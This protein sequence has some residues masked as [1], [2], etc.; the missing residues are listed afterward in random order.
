MDTEEFSGRDG[1]RC[2]FVALVGRPNVG[3]STLLNAL[4]G[5]KISIVTP[6]PQTT[7]HRINGILTLDGTQLVFVDTPGLHQRGRKALNAALNRTA[8]AS[9]S[10]VDVV[11]F[12][13]EAGRW[14]DEDEAVLRHLQGVRAPVGL[15]LNKVDR[16]ADR[17]R[18]L[19]ELQK[20][21]ERR[22]FAFV[23]PLS[24]RRRDNLDALIGEVQRRLPESPFLYPDDQ[25]TDRSERFLV[26]EVVREK[27]VLALHDELPYELTVEVER[28]ERDG[29]LLT[30]GAV[31]WVAKT[32]HKGIVI[33][34]G[35][36][37]LKH[38]GE[39]ARLEL[40]ERFGEKV[41]LQLWVKVKEGWHE[42]ERL[43]RSLGVDES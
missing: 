8:L 32:S 4:V 13:V 38:V 14:T 28:F 19:P 31:I 3:K 26:A 5:E 15:V 9:L 20:L 29:R 30:L 33:G 2:G 39:K 12:V 25:P 11:L 27:L 23:V 35:G 16:V 24:A 7:R 36:H 42:S 22:E 40:E 37:T 18:L 1:A 41:H 17:S 34:R 10:D 6:K 43:L 21:A